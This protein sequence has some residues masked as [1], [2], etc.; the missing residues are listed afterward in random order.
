MI[1]VCGVVPLQ[2][3]IGQITPIL[4]KGKKDAS[5]CSSYRPIT[6]SCTT[7]KLFESFLTRDIEENCS[8]P[9][10]QFGYQRGLGREHALFLLINVL[11]DIEERGDFLVLCAL[12]VA[13]AFDSCIFSQVLLEALLKGTDAAVITC[14]RYMYRNLKAGIKDGSQLQGAFTILKGVRQG[15][16]TSHI[17]CL[18]IVTYRCSG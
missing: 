9:P 5:L 15:A 10:R 6:I 12:D 16:V 18:K 13:R 1:L 17:F 14:L 4:K 3:C 11:K 7:F 2:F 8:T